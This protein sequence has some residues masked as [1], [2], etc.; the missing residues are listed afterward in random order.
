MERSVEVT[1]L[2]VSLSGGAQF[3]SR[4]GTEI[5]LSDVFNGFLR[6]SRG[7]PGCGMT[8]SFPILL[9]FTESDYPFHH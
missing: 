6:P 2:L 3:K 4:D 1:T 8:A 7:M 9:K 5:T